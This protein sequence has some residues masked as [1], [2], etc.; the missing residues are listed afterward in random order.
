MG[1]RKFSVHNT[2]PM[3]K[4]PRPLRI[5]AL[6]D[7]NNYYNR[8][9]LVGIRQFVRSREGWMCEPVVPH[10]SPDWG[11]L[12]EGEWD[13][14]V[15]FAMSSS[16]LPFL[17][18]ARIPAVNVSNSLPP[19]DHITRVVS[20]DFAVGQLAA[21][22]FLE[23][24]LRYFAFFGRTETT[25]ARERHLGFAKTLADAGHTCE[26]LWPDFQFGK[27]RAIRAEIP[28]ME[29]RVAQGHCPL[30]VFCMNDI[31]AR[32]VIGCCVWHRIHVPEQVA[33]VGVDNSELADGMAEMPFS[34]VELRL[35][36]IGST[37]MSVL[38]DLIAGGQPPVSPILVTPRRVVTRASSDLIAVSDPMIVRTL[39]LIRE[40][41][42]QPMQIDEIVREIPL[43]RRMLERRFKAAIGR[44]PYAEVLRLRVEKARALL[45]DTDL[46]VAEVAEEC[47]FGQAKQLHAIFTRET[48]VTP[49]LFRKN[50]RTPERPA[51]ARVTEF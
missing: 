34:S 21:R 29:A 16:L 11:W 50:C 3:S 9:V 35:E 30:G 17:E 32:Y 25:V 46:S 4:P 13:G 15:T 47:G 28:G 51:A 31:Y 6:L 33:V 24:G 5:A 18:K 36:K 10:D 43:S 19:G 39:R 45:A 8:S 22:H 26:L 41:A 14:V 44:S 23:R 12:L 40:R 27:E 2:P 20:D 37:A 7:L 49:S 1:A 42:Y 38:G 48:G